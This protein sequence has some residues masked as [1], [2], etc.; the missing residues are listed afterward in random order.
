MT[1]FRLVRYSGF[2]LKLDW[3]LNHNKLFRVDGKMLWVSWPDTWTASFWTNKLQSFPLK[4]T[5]STMISVKDI[6]DY[7]YEGEWG[8]TKPQHQDYDSLISISHQRWSIDFLPNSIT[9]KRDVPRLST[10]HAHPGA[11]WESTKEGGERQKAM[12]EVLSSQRG[13][14]RSR[15]TNRVLNLPWRWREA[16]HKGTIFFIFV[17][18]VFQ[19]HEKVQTV[20]K[21]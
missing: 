21:K 19:P 5:P 12:T 10:S 9:V 3:Y 6:S 2:I 18:G 15:I 4:N 14:K 13:A 11:R 1:Y 17:T 16:G 20:S 7:N 8:S